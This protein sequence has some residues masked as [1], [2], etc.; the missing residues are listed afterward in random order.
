L[1]LLKNQNHQFPVRTDPS[2]S[3]GVNA[4]LASNVSFE[5]LA[6]EEASAKDGS[7]PYKLI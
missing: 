3:S 2:A 6:K 5:A 7:N 1:L 4:R